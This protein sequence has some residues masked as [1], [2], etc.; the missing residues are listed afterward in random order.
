MRNKL[1][2]KIIIPLWWS[3]NTYDYI[4]ESRH[5]VQVGKL[6][7]LHDVTR[8]LTCSF[9][10]PHRCAQWTTYCNSMAIRNPC[11][12]ISLYRLAK[13]IHSY[14]HIHTFLECAEDHAAMGLV[15]ILKNS[16]P[17]FRDNHCSNELHPEIFSAGRQGCLAA[18]WYS[19]NEWIAL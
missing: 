17:T 10:T 6:W 12:H 16:S 3:T 8:R 11:V 13:Y 1:P 18:P 19:L 15:N 4:L 5:L 7:H 14:T 2:A 9:L